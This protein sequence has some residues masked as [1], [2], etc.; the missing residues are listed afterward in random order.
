MSEVASWKPDVLGPGYEMITLAMG[1][2][3]EGEV[4]ATLVR[5]AGDQ[6]GRRAV[7]YVHGYIVL[8]VA[9]IAYLAPKLGRNVTCVR[10][11]GAIHDV[12]LSQPAARHQAFDELSDWLTAHAPDPDLALS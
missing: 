10:I 11:A 6:K 7:L 4:T 3:Y 9:Q 8:D 2:D 12:F 1:T 5:R